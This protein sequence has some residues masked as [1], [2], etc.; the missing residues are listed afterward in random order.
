LIAANRSFDVW[1]GQLGQSY[2]PGDTQAF[3]MV[4]HRSA[5]DT[6]LPSQFFQRAAVLVLGSDACTF[7]RGQSTL[8]WFRWA[9]RST[10]R[11]EGVDALDACTGRPG[12]GV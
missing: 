1:Q 5:M 6:E 7:K 3:K 9:S 10:S 4:G 11:G 2:P 12:A 8:D